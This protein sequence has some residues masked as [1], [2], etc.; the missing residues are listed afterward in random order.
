MAK[1]TGFG[2]EVIAGQWAAAEFGALYR[3]WE[4]GTEL[5]VRIVP[6]PVQILGTE[7]LLEFLGTDDGQAAPR[8]AQLRPE[9]EELTD[10][11]WSHTFEVNIH[12]YFRVTSAALAHLGASAASTMMVGDDVETDVLAAQRQ[13]LTGAL[14]KTGKYLPRTLAGASGTPDHVLGSFADYGTWRKRTLAEMEFAGQHEMLNWMALIGAMEA[15]DR[16]PPVIQDYMET[17]ILA[18][19]KCFLSF[20]A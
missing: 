14:V 18:S 19:D 12:S 7:L 11:Q 1:R 20:P 6:Y 17:Y 15:L 9:P 16:K 4:V 2:R 10:H 13:G 3:L 5:G 8:L